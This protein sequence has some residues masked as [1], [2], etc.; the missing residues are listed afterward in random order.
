MGECSKNKYLRIGLISAR[1]MVLLTLAIKV[2]L[3][4][5]FVSV[6]V[7]FLTAAPAFARDLPEPESI[8]LFAIGTVGL[9]LTLRKKK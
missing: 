3:M 2:I 4:R 6:L 7:M 8:S 1:C 9:L 5:N